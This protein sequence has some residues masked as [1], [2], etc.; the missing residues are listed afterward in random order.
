MDY[1]SHSRDTSRMID[2]LANLQPG[3]LACMHGSAWT[4]DG[5]SLLRRLGES[6]AQP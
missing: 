6:L 3:V 1:F 4:G 5:A 2:K